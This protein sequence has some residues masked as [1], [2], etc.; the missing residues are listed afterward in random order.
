MQSLIAFIDS[1]C[2]CWRSQIAP[3]TVFVGI[4]GVKN[5]AQ[6]LV[7]AICDRQRLRQLLFE[8]IKGCLA[9]QPFVQ[10][11]RY[12][13]SP[14]RLFVFLAFFGLLYLQKTLEILREICYNEKNCANF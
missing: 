2:R 13:R 3:T 5:T 4:L 7:G 9:K 8:S 10:F 12:F 11:F 6:T 14:M 1:C